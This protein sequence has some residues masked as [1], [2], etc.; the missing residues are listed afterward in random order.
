[1][2]S[3]GLCRISSC[4]VRGKQGET[5]STPFRCSAP[6]GHSPGFEVDL[7]GLD[8]FVTQPECD[9]RTIHSGLQQFHCGCVSKHM[10]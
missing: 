6:C 7:G 1:M 5:A 8:R 10:W 9:E 2:P 3:S 4:A